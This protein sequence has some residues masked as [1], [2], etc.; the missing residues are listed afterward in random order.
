ML[1]LYTDNR[2]TLWVCP[3][4]L[5]TSEIVTWKNG[6]YNP[7][8]TQGHMTAEEKTAAPKTKKETDL[9]M[10]TNGAIWLTDR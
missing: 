6:K 7:I 9:I 2:G 1:N 8:N 5:V 4:K 10:D 3:A